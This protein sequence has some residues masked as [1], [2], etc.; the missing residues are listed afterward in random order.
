MQP[1]LKISIIGTRGY[2][3]FYGGF[4]TALRN[5]VPYFAEQGCKVV[6]Y[7]RKKHVRFD[8]RL[9]TS[10]IQSITTKGFDFKSLSTLTHGAT[11]T[12]HI[13]RNKPDAVLVMNVA[14]GYFLPFLKFFKIPTVVNV[15]GIEWERKKW[16]RL[17]QVVFKFGAYLCS[18]FADV[19]V[20]DSREIARIWKDRF[21]R[22]LIYIPYGASEHIDL[23]APADLPLSEYILYV[24]R[25]VPENSIEVFLDAIENETERK[26]VIVGREALPGSIEARIEKLLLERPHIVWL[27]HI[28]DQ[29]FLASLWKYC[30]LYFH[31]HTVGGTNP[32]LVQA[33][34]LGAP[35]LAVDTQFNRETLAEGGFFTDA[36]VPSIQLALKNAFSSGDLIEEMKI[37]NSIRVRN[38]YNWQ[39]VCEK[40]YQTLLGVYYLRKV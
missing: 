37:M 34:H 11:A 21:N 5:L 27:K 33:M 18:K 19:L 4:E 38:E 39:L 23:V 12:L 28:N 3:S 36:S 8:S 24:A 31:G 20:A 25:L 14:N 15:D 16:S 13:L 32:A 17:G 9:L 30:G 29:D 1:Q 22:E 40:Y 2:P 6:I 7:G 35:I 10:R 26:V